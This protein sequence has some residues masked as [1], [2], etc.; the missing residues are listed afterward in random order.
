MEKISSYNSSANVKM[1]KTWFLVVAG[2]ATEVV[3]LVGF[4]TI[5]GASGI[6]TAAT[7]GTSGL[8]AVGLLL[9][10]AGMLQLRKGFDPTQR[11]V[12]KGLTLQGF[13][14]IGLFFGVVL[15]GVISSL[16]SYLVSAAFVAAS[17]A[18][19]LAGAVLLRRHYINTGAP[20]AKTVKYLI[21]GMALVFSGVG[22]IVGS[23]IAFQYLISQVENTV[24]VDIGATVSACGFVLAALSFD[25][26]GMHIAHVGCQSPNMMNRLS[27]RRN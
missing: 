14:L 10:A 18:L 1:S 15:T 16:A 12:R 5:N 4:L 2:F 23:N 11:A 6:P 7:V 25:R 21:L 24:Y 20:N 8:V 13:G 27:E 22:M 19:G 3:A 17:S 26:I 9:P